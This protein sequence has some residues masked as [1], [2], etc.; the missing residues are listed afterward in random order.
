MRV[1]EE[2]ARTR[3][4][5]T[6]PSDEALQRSGAELQTKLGATGSRHYGPYLQP[7]EM[8]DTAAASDSEKASYGP[9]ENSSGNQNG[10]VVTDARPAQI[11][12]DNQAMRDVEKAEEEQTEIPKSR[13]QMDPNIVDWDGPEDPHN[14]M[15]WT[16]TKKWV[17]TISFAL[18]TFC[19]TFASSVFSTATQVTAQLF[20]VSEEVMILGT[21]LFVLVSASNS[22]RSKVH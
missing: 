20:G 2:T 13:D 6:Q 15:N 8:A 10:R 11:G 19:I 16:I 17:V 5:S 3:V 21:S 22:S 7:D 4:P 14:P 12:D 9:R 18:M 1:S